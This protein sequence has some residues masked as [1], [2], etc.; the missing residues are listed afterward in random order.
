MR[1]TTM[2]TT[3]V[4]TTTMLTTTIGSP[5]GE[6]VLTGS[7]DGLAGVYFGPGAPAKATGLPRDDAAFRRCAAEF[8]AYF[9][10]TSTCIDVPVVL[11]GTPFQRDVWAL[12]QQ[13]PYGTTTTYGA[14]ARELGRPGAS[15]AVGLAN[16]RNAVG[17]VVPCHRVVG[18][19]GSLT[20]YAGGLE[21]KRWLLAHERSHRGDGLF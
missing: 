7:D 2:L 16:G 13:I 20:G 21:V 19:D 5:L 17:V 3:T 4:L 6:V 14:L 8:A 10:G 1:T 12:L 18:S 11:T 9:A 15:R